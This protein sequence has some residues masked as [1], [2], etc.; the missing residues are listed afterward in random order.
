MGGL[1]DSYEHA[2][3]SLAFELIRENLGKPLPADDDG[4]WGDD[5]AHRLADEHGFSGA[6]VGA[7]KSLAFRCLRYGYGAAILSAPEDRLIQWTKTGP[8]TAGA[9]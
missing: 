7:A 8:A 5:V 9:A 2:I 1:G 3:Q 4:K 6:Q